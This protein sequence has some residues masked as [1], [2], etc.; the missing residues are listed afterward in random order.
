[1]NERY[2][3]AVGS[4]IPEKVDRETLFLFDIGN[5][6]YAAFYSEGEGLPADMRMPVNIDHKRIK[7]STIISKRIE[8]TMVYDLEAKN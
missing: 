2:S 7:D 4:L 8:S 5:K 1:M 3:E 6:H